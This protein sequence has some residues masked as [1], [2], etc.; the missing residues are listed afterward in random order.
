[1]R[2]AVP[3]KAVIRHGDVVGCS[4]P[5]A[6]Q[7]GTCSRQWSGRNQGLLSILERTGQ[8]PVEFLGDWPREPAVAPLLSR[9]GNA[10]RQN[11]TA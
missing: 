2:F 4:L 10:E 1:M 6:H 5:L 11:V 3:E 8:E 9:I 7:D